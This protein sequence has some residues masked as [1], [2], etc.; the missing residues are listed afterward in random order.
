[1]GHLP[2]LAS[3]F[4]PAS[5]RLFRSFEIAVFCHGSSPLP[6]DTERMAKNQGKLGT[7]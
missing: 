4:K 3:L 5:C 2:F 7:Y 1:M 6:N